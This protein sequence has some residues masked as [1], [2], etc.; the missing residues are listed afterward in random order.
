MSQLTQRWTYHEVVEAEYGKPGL[1]ALKVAIIINNAGS[2]VC[3]DSVQCCC[4]VVWF[5]VGCAMAAAI[6]WAAMHVL[7]C[8]NARSC[9]GPTARP[10]V[11]GWPR[12]QLLHTLKPPKEARVP[13]SLPFSLASQI[14]YLIIIADVLCGVA[15]EYNGLITNLVGVHDPSG[16]FLQYQPPAASHSA[17]SQQF[18]TCWSPLPPPLLPQVS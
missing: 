1:M 4:F 18:P 8:P 13:L 7:V 2:M 9:A 15:P 14:V 6:F 10:P 17:C 5:W 11:L 3:N 12:S 16:E